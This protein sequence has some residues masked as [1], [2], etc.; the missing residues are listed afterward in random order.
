MSEEVMQA[1]NREDYI[2]SQEKQ[3]QKWIINVKCADTPTNSSIS[4]TFRTTACDVIS[5]ITTNKVISTGS[6]SDIVDHDIPIKRIKAPTKKPGILL[7]NP[8]E[9]IV[10]SSSDNNQVRL[11]DTLIKE[12]SMF[13]NKLSFARKLRGKAENVAALVIQS[14]YRRHFVLKNISSIKKASMLRLNY[15]LAVQQRLSKLQSANGSGSCNKNPIKE[16]LTRLQK[17]Y[18]NGI[19]NPQLS[20]TS[21]SITPSNTTSSSSDFQSL[22]VYRNMYLQ[23]RQN[24]ISKIQRS[25]RC[26]GSRRVLRSKRAEYVHI[27]SAWASNVMQSIVRGFVAKTRVVRLMNQRKHQ[28][29]ERNALL[30]Q[31]VYRRLYSK[32]RVHRRR[33]QL[34]YIAAR[35]IQ[36]WFRKL[37]AVHCVRKLDS[38]RRNTIFNVSATT[39]QKCARG[40][41]CRCLGRWKRIRRR[42]QFLIKYNVT[43]KIQR[44]VRRFLAVCS[45]ASRRVRVK[46][47]K[48]KQSLLQQ[49]E[50]KKELEMEQEKERQSLIDGMDVFRQALTGDALVVGDLMA[51]SLDEHVP[52]FGAHPSDT[53]NAS[54][55]TVL[56]IA[57]TN[58]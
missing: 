11:N 6:M 41:I 47:E 8:L 45:V 27:R 52:G 43:T 17:Q 4:W 21:T 56:S 51:A 42:K 44:I 10:I 50:N 14:Y 15:R 57:I 26:Y 33:Y 58:G 1:D 49:E 48:N 39:I 38:I 12:K 37:V 46:L 20:S 35:M 22:R 34:H 25:Y 40:Y 28:K 5:V 29:L 7:N 24:M 19:E 13:M 18:R 9:D 54:G 36:C 3:L 16:L 2:R 23:L 30:I 32:K 55:E 31:K 53:T